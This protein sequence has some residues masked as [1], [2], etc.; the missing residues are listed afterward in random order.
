MKKEKLDPETQ[1]A[2]RISFLEKFSFRKKL[3]QDEAEEVKE[4][5][6]LNGI[7]ASIVSEVQKGKLLMVKKIKRAIFLT[8]VRFARR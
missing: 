6:R 5:A 8:I 3:T 1:Q 7:P 4:E 2:F